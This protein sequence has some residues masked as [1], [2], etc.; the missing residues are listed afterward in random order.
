MSQPALREFRRLNV[1]AELGL[2][3][4]AKRGRV[5]LDRPACEIGG[6]RSILSTFWCQILG[7]HFCC[8]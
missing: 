5:E 7:V 8:L 3:T 2:P 1:E 4:G 6:F